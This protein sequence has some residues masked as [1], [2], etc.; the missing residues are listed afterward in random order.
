M[1]EME[2]VVISV[3][4]NDMILAKKCEMNEAMWKVAV[5]KNSG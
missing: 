4:S 2:K 1:R 3:E 5:E